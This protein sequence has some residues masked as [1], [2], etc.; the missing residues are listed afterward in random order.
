LSPWFQ[1]RGGYGGEY[2][3]IECIVV[4]RYDPDPVDGRE[5]C[6]D[7][8]PLVD[9]KLCEREVTPDIERWGPVA[10][11]LAG[12]YGPEDFGL[13]SDPGSRHL[14]PLRTI[15]AVTET[16]LK[17]EGY[18]RENAG[19]EVIQQYDWQQKHK[20]VADRPLF[21]WL[22]RDAME[23]HLVF[24]REYKNFEAD[25]P[26]IEAVLE[27]S[28]TGADGCAQNVVETWQWLQELDVPEEL[29]TRQAG[30]DTFGGGRAD[31]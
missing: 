15:S 8:T 19:A 26:F 4:D 3:P 17:T 21:E 30:I 5:D 11:D 31:V 1:D 25:E 10:R 20:T 7:T 27:E 24:Y 12:E 16:P 9:C 22:L 6:P 2:H 23:A 14:D 13:D 18:L 29:G 28:G